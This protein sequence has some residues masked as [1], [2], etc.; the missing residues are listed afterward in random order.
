MTVVPPTIP[1]DA[2]TCSRLQRNNCVK[3]SE[4]NEDSEH[5]SKNVQ[6]NTLPLFG[7]TTRTRA[8]AKNFDIRFLI[9]ELTCKVIAGSHFSLLLF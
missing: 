3:F 8:V 2:S 5:G 9:V 1:T 4:I 6:A 7:A